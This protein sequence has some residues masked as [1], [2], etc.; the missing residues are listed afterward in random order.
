MNDPDTDTTADIST[1]D[2][3]SAMTGSGEVREG[4]RFDVATLQ[5]YLESEMEG[6]EGPLQVEEFRGGQSNPTYKLISPSGNY[7]MRR[8]PPGELLKSAHAV[9]REY[10]VMTQLGPTDVPVPGTHLLC[11][12]DSVVG[13]WFYIMDFADGRVL[14]ESTLPGMAPAERG[15][16]YD[17][18][19]K[20]LALL[21]Q[22]DPEA[23]GLG[24][25]GRAGSYIARQVSRWSKQ[26][27]LSKTQEIPEMDKL[28]AWLPENIPEDEEST[29]VH[30][31]Y[32]LD[33]LVYHPQKN[34]IIA[35]L[36]WEIS[37]IGH[38]LADF[39]YHCMQWRTEGGLGDLD[40]ADLG[41]PSEDEYVQR[42]CERTGRSE[43][44][45]WDYYMA[46]NMFKLA[47]ITQGIM[48]RF[49]DGTAASAFA[50]E[51]GAAAASMAAQGWSQAQ[52]LK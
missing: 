15:E 46:F 41:I 11:Q 35:I 26:Y 30:G 34:E 24:D 14:W 13:S 17:S 49:R 25:F 27:E 7:V 52:K 44:P 2:R 8:K 18:M 50:G 37:T 23:V 3:Q 33:N 1:I 6:F 20:T 38:P 47:G 4:H 36:D 21:H 29:I 12:D 43:I 32:R 45:H 39:S 40:L 9:D 31:D 19:N 42:Y 28:M 10:R 5:A 16:I 51:Y 22:V 48:G